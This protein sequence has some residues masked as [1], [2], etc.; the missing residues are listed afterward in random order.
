MAI[1]LVL[2]ALVALLTVA[3]VLSLLAL[4]R[5]RRA[6]APPPGPPAPRDPFDP[7]HSTAGDPRRLRAGDMVEF[8][9][10]RLFVRGS[11]RLRQ[12]GYTWSEHYVD[13][14]DVDATGGGAMDVAAAPAAGDGAGRRW[15]SVEEDPDLEVMLWTPYRGGAE[16]APSERTLTVEGVTYHRTEHGLADYQSE[17]TTGLAPTGRVEYADFEGPGGR[18]LAFERFLG[19][20]GRGAW[21]VALGERVPHGTLV[22]YPGSDG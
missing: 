10:E 5:R 17:G 8:L 2:V 20:D 7:G 21:E 18:G 12:G 16:L 3:L 1:S 19:P 15:I 22:I 9:G 13:A 4:A 6:T 14:M 11:L